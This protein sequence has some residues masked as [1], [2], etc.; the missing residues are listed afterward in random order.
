MLPPSACCRLEERQ[1]WVRA[2]ASIPEGCRT[3]LAPCSRATH[4][5]LPPAHQ[6]T[7]SARCTVW[8]SPSPLLPRPCLRTGECTRPTHLACAM[9]A[10]ASASSY[11]SVHCPHTA[12]HLS[13]WPTTSCTAA[14]EQ[15]QAHKPFSS[16]ISELSPH[17]NYQSLAAYTS[18]S[19]TAVT[20]HA[21][22]AGRDHLHVRVLLFCKL[23]CVAHQSR[24]VR[25]R[26]CGV[27][28]HSPIPSYCLL[29]MAV[30]RDG[31][32]PLQAT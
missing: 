23:R 1:P 31:M 7:M 25:S 3:V 5:R 8:P 12:S 26:L 21:G 4:H 15:A 32:K 16:E 10:C 30:M 2:G 18:R 22:C 6:H 29:V 28:L 13:R 14:A 17:L 19:P 11:Y 9:H 24:L 20:P 27:R